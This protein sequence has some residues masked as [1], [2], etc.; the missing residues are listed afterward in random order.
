MLIGERSTGDSD[1]LVQHDRWW[2]R[3][4]ILT[5]EKL[6]FLWDEESKFRSLFSDLT[7]GDF[8]NYLAVYMDPNSIWVEVM[9]GPQTVGI[10]CWMGM[11]T[12]IDVEA[13]ITFFDRRPAEKLELCK[14]L[15][16]WFFEKN[17][18]V[19][20]MSASIPIIYHATIRLAEHIGFKRE[21]LKRQS[22]L[23][24]GKR[25]DEVLLGLLA[26]EMD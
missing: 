20:R 18:Q 9:D 14:K 16:R 1:I 23:L 17:P 22:Q 26:T 19:H 2:V 24:G 12:V 4:L 8:D 13:H 6:Q 7:R 25:I 5:P 21:G 3:E 15:A 10:I 11:Q